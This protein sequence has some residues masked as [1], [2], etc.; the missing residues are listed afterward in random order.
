MSY[1]AIA[2]AA[3]D[4]AL[5]ARIAA[6]IATQGSTAEHPTQTADRLLWACA[7]QPGWGEAWASAQAAGN[8]NPGDDPAVISDPQIL[9]AVQ[10][11]LA[12]PPV[13]EGTNG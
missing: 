13:V 11:I 8:P 5:R 2:Q 6:C 4:G 10:K 1:T 12:P 7:A 9:A 3:Q